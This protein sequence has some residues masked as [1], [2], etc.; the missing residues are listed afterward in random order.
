MLHY[1]NKFQPAL[2][3]AGPLKSILKYALTIIEE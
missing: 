2:F 1:L 3:N